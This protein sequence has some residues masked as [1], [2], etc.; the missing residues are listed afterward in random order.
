M[1]IANSVWCG[2]LKKGAEDSSA[3]PGV[4]PRRVAVAQSRCAR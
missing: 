2:W 3:P 4:K 1:I